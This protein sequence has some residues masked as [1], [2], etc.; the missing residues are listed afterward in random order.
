MTAAF[1]FRA[2]GA[3]DDARLYEIWLEA[4]RATHHFLTPAD[5]DAI[6]REVREHYVGQAALTVAIDGD[7][8]PLG[9]MGMTGTH[10]DALFVDPACHGRGIGRALVALSRAATVDVNEQNPGATGFYAHL[11]FAVVG[12][13]PLD[14]DRRP[15]PILHLR[16][17]EP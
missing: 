6:G 16:R 12:R 11:G 5:L 13:S 7:G 14:G 17:A 15:Y 3:D 1:S 10:I 9:F 2:S 8:W 4:V